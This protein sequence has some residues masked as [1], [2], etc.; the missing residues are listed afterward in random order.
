M[1]PEPL[2]TVPGTVLLTQ[3]IL[4]TWDIPSII[5][6]CDL[7]TGLSSPVPPWKLWTMPKHDLA[8]AHTIPK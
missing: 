5:R 4:N 2:A 6:W 1:K 8:K 7:T 3:A